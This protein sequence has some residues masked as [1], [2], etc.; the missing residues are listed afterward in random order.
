[1]AVL[2]DRERNEV[3]GLVKSTANIWDDS[4]AQGCEAILATT[5]PLQCILLIST[6]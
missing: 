4:Q 1:M 6:E 3:E 5:A 2:Q